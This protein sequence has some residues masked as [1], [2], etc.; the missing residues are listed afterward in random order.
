[1]NKIVVYFLRL[2]CDGRIV[3]LKGEGGID[4]F[5][6]YLVIKIFKLVFLFDIASFQHYLHHRSSYDFGYDQLAL[7]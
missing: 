3:I 2:F 1:M 6:T 4:I 7:C 5:W